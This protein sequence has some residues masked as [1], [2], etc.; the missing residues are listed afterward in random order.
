MWDKS[1]SLNV[2]ATPRRSAS[3][4]DAMRRA[5]PL[6][7]GLTVAAT[8]TAQQPVAGQSD[9]ASDL[10]RTFVELRHS[11][12]NAQYSDPRFFTRE[13]LE[14]AIRGALASRN[15]PN[16]PGVARRSG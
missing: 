7:M 8:G 16:R 3:S 13:W 4:L 14:G 2:G 6:I 11:V 1:A 5:L 9:T 12:G 10:Y 15:Q